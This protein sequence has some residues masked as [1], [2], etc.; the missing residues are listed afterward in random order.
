M[1]RGLHFRTNVR[2]P[3]RVY[4]MFSCLDPHFEFDTHFDKT[5]KNQ[6]FSPFSIS[7][8]IIKN[9]FKIPLSPYKIR[10]LSNSTENTIYNNEITHQK[11]SIHIS[12]ITQNTS[13]IN[14]FQ[15]YQIHKQ[16]YSIE[17]IIFYHQIHIK[18]TSK[19]ILISYIN[20]Q[21]T[22]IPNIPYL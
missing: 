1:G 2:L 12:S 10:L 9:S 7:P 5:L 19:V 18:L 16:H 14:T 13:K 21:T 4:L 20:N 3:E 22:P 6:C 11:P 8:K 15:S 17:V